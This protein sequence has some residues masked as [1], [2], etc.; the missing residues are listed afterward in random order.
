LSGGK[1]ANELSDFDSPDLTLH[2][3]TPQY[4]NTWIMDSRAPHWYMHNR[5]IFFTL[6]P[7]SE[8]CTGITG[9]Q[10]NIEGIGSVTFQT[11]KSDGSI[12][13][14]CVYKV[15]YAPG[16]KANILSTVMTSEKGLLL[17]Q[18]DHTTSIFSSGGKEM[19][20]AKLVGD[21]D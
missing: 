14:L 1:N 4:C 3:G 13:S 5:S 15:Y 16:I 9:H 2:I 6:Q 11:T 10:T 21:A 19:M 12:G 17:Q 7:I 20:C 18:I 8:T